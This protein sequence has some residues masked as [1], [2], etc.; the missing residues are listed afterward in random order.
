M[1][2]NKVAPSLHVMV[3]FKNEGRYNFVIEQKRK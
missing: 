3:D 2:F 1:I